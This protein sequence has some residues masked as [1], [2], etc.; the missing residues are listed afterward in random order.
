MKAKSMKANMSIDTYHLKPS[1][2]LEVLRVPYSWG[3][4]YPFGVQLDRNIS[5]SAIDIHHLHQGFTPGLDEST[6]SDACFYVQ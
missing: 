1:L 2:T 4:N 3:H 5:P 6:I